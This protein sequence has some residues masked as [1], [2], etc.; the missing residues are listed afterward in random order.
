MDI[1]TPAQVLDFWFSEI[2]P[3]MWFKKS[4][5]FDA[6]IA[7]RFGDTTRRA[8]DGGLSE[9]ATDADGCLALI[10]VL[11]QFARNIYRDTPDA[12]AGDAQAIKLSERCVAES[13]IE[14]V[15]ESKRTFMLM[16]MMHSEDLNVQEASLSLFKTYTPENNYDYAVKHRDIIARFGRFPHRNRILGRENTVREAEF[17]TKPGSSF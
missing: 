6:E 8:L 3:E 16:P 7:R 9:W 12:F 1:A 2:E 13:F 11:D 5:E 10:L 17:L 14:V 15:E 4:D